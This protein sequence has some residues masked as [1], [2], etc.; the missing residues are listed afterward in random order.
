[1][2]PND[3]QNLLGLTQQLNK[4]GYSSL[5]VRLEHLDVFRLLLTRSNRRTGNASLEPTSCQDLTR[6]EDTSSE[7]VTGSEKTLPGGEML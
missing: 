7:E 3:L 2:E 5:V 6:L 4:F 1:M